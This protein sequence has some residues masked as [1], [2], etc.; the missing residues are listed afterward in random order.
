MRGD[1]GEDQ[2]GP[3]GAVIAGAAN[4][5]DLASVG[6]G[7][8]RK[9]SHE[10]MVPGKDGDR[11]ADVLGGP[12]ETLLLEESADTPTV[13][14]TGD[15][16]RPGRALRIRQNGGRLL[17][18]RVLRGLELRLQVHSV[19]PDAGASHIHNRRGR[20]APLPPDGRFVWKNELPALFDGPPAENGRPEITVPAGM[21][22]PR[23]VDVV[24][25]QRPG[26]SLGTTLV[27]LLK[28]DDVGVLEGIASEHLYG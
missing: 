28:R 8:N 11:L 3:N 1:Q 24:E 7:R 4:V 18:T 9:P 14:V 20:V 16:H 17:L 2:T 22:R 21:D 15:D 13:E 6:G 25:V 27:H 26:D 5:P 12:G 23:V 19:D 10:D